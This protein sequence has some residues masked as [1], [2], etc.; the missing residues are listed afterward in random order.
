MEAEASGSPKPLK[1]EGGKK[2][3]GGSRKRVP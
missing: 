3:G 1:G 2:M